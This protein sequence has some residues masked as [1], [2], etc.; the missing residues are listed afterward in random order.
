[1]TGL[2]HIL[3]AT[4]ARYPHAIAITDQTRSIT[5]AE[6]N[7]ETNRMA[8]QLVQLGIRPTNRVAFW[9]DKSIDAI[10]IMQAAMRVGAVYVPLDP[11]SPPE[12]I[13]RILETCEATCVV[14]TTDRLT[15]LQPLSCC[16]MLAIDGSRQMEDCNV[17]IYASDP[18]DLAYILHTSGSTG[19]PKG[20]CV[21]HRAAMAFIDWAATE[22]APTPADRFAN[23]APLHFDLS[24]LD[25]YVSIRAGAR[26]FLI[27][28]TISYVP[29]NLTDFVRRH[30]I[31]IW[32]S[33]PSALTLMLDRGALESEAPQLALRVI[34]FAGEVFPIGHL[35]RLHRAL[36]G[37]RLLNLYGPTETNVCTFFEVTNVPADYV[38]PMP[39]GRAC[40][41]NQVWAQNEVGDVCRPG[42]IGELV[43]E[44]PTVM[45]RYWGQA[46]LSPPYHTGDLVRAGADGLYTF[47]G[48]TDHMVKIRGHRVELGEIE[49]TLYVQL[50]AEVAELAVVVAGTGDA[51]RLRACIV[52][53][54]DRPPSLL[55]CKQLCAAHLPRYMIVDE[56][57]YLDQMAR[58]RNGKVDRE[59]LVA[60]ETSPGGER[61]S[62]G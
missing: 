14:S 39:I 29:Q 59:Y 17:Q 34:C 16:N 13:N 15:R 55:R 47:I 33:V 19:V 12:R 45:S 54:T 10:V 52:A 49:K 8:H 7:V 48:R 56:V 58:T 28:D 22:I 57:I 27:A 62:N 21:S 25:I 51:A 60:M 46:A 41:G 53:K 9:L 32:Y 2:H 35:R 44:G 18:E 37:V 1:M 31:T 30:R 6:L 43:V 3:I 42:E 26:L 23:H 24:V 50:S 40:C 20:V 61:H 5:Y 38:D 11:L 4:A 36:P